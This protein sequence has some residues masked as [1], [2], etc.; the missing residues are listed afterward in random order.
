MPGHGRRDGPPWRRRTAAVAGDQLR[1]YKLWRTDRCVTTRCC[2]S[3]VAHARICREHAP[4]ACRIAPGRDTSVRGRPRR[5]RGRVAAGRAG[6]PTARR[7]RR[8]AGRHG[9]PFRSRGSGAGER[10]MD[11]EPDG[12]GRPPERAGEHER[13]HSPAASGQPQRGCGSGRPPALGPPGRDR[14]LGGDR[15]GERAGYRRPRRWPAAGGYGQGNHIGAGGLPLGRAPW[16]QSGPT[17][18]R[19]AK[20]PCGPGRRPA[21][22]VEQGSTN[23]GIRGEGFSAPCRR[24]AGEASP[25]DNRGHRKVAQDR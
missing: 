1:H 13:G 2:A 17:R 15:A 4:R 6:V 25:A 9:R 7:P 11:G 5:P 22:R 12:A 23:V 24:N 16:D 8:P 14:M 3:T 20:P 19:H 18:V 21:Q 10:P